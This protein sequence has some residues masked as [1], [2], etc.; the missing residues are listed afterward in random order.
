MKFDTYTHICA[1]RILFN[2]AEEREVAKCFALTYHTQF[3]FIAVETS[4]VHGG[5]SMKFT[6]HVSSKASKKC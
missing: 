5:L 2:K 3:Q 4:R 6:E 1:A